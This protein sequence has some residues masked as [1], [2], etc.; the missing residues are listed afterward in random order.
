MAGTFATMGERSG[1]IANTHLNNFA[2]LKYAD[3]K[4]TPGLARGA[5]QCPPPRPLRYTD[6]KT[7]PSLLRSGAVLRSPPQ[8]ARPGPRNQQPSISGHDGSARRFSFDLLDGQDNPSIGTQIDDDAESG[9]DEATDYELE[10][11]LF[12]MI[13]RSTE[14]LS[15]SETEK[16][17]GSGKKSTSP[18]KKFKA[19]AKK[20][21]KGMV[22]VV[23]RRNG[24]SGTY[25]KI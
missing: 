1:S 13:N 21:S 20:V 18:L 12:D 7:N 5:S 16:E 14:R 22:V 25:M 2:R 8:A 3:P 9:K 24:E 23:S 19:S 6:T 15:R 11:E 17:E 10:L 4:T